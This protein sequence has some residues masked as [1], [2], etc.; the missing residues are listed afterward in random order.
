MVSYYH[1]IQRHTR[2]EGDQDVWCAII[3]RKNVNFH[4]NELPLSKDLALLIVLTMKINRMHGH[5][6][7][8][9]DVVIMIC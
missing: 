4:L 6:D 5:Q 1:K 2:D 8:K 9:P 7:E 3:Q